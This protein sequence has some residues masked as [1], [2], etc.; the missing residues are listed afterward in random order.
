MEKRSTHL[1]ALVRL[2]LLV[3]TVG[4]AVSSAFS[5]RLFSESFDYR[6]GELGGNGP[7]PGSPPGQGAWVSLVRHA[8]V[9]T[10]GL[11]FRSF[12]SAGNAASV[13]DDGISFDGDIVAADVTPL[14]G[15][16]GGIVWIGFFIQSHT[17]TFGYGTL[18]FNSGFGPTA[19]QFGAIYATSRYGIDNNVIPTEDALTIVRPSRA[20]VWM[21]VELDFNTG[22]E[23]LFL[24]PRQGVEPIRARAKARLAMRPEFQA[25]GF[26][27][28]A[29][30]EGRT[31]GSY[32]FDEIRVGTTFSDLAP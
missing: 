31:G 27:R 29:L 1:P 20:V 30:R 7:P 17:P 6:T 25:S 5:E 11:L 8:Q 12:Q 32:T 22:E 23:F 24:N 26:N 28:I 14:G 10:P 9:I 3:L 18:T 2:V 21:V 19:P 15:S 16:G 4:F 13:S